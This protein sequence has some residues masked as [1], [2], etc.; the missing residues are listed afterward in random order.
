MRNPQKGEPTFSLE[1]REAMLERV[2]RAHP[3]ECR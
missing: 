1:E 3:G 2:A